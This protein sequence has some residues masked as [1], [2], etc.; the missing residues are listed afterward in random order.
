MVYLLVKLIHVVSSSVLFGT[1]LGTAFYMWRV[2]QGESIE[3]IAKATKQVVFADWCFTGTSGVIQLV[4]G[5]YLLYLKGYTPTLPWVMISLMGY[6][7]AGVCWFV[8]VWL[9]IQCQRIAKR[10]AQ[11][12][13]PLP[14][15]YWRY[16]RYWWCL[17]LPAFAALLVVFYC[18]VNKPMF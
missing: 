3:L 11:D 15:V 4:T 16:Y 12:H 8:V 9:Q 18:M 2:N 10:C 1:G 17:G 7:I 14:A 5:S 6:A 13:M